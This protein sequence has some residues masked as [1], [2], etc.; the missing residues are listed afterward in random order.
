MILLEMS[1]TKMNKG[2]ACTQISHTIHTKSALDYCCRAPGGKT[3]GLGISGINLN[4]FFPSFPPDDRLLPPSSSFRSS[5]P[6]LGTGFRFVLFFLD[7]DSPTGVEVIGGRELDRDLEIVEE[8][9]A[10]PD[11][12]SVPTAEGV[13]RGIK[14]LYPAMDLGTDAR[15]PVGSTSDSGLAGGEMG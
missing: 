3:A 12:A 14:S 9:V 6:R 2:P 8:G 11:E 5:G 1:Y 10:V 13:P 15:R 7:M 4:S